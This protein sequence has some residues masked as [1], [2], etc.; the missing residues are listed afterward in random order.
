MVG[1][2]TGGNGGRFGSNSW[3]AAVPVV[4]TVI[5]CVATAGAQVLQ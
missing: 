1:S 3:N 2:G 5:A 4:S